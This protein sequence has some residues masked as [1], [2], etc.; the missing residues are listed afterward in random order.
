[1]SVNTFATLVSIENLEY[2]ILEF[3]LT[4]QMIIWKHQSRNSSTSFHSL[5]MI[6][7]T[8]VKVQCNFLFN[9]RKQKQCYSDQYILK[10]RLH[11]YVLSRFFSSKFTFKKDLDK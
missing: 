2:D 10:S 5:R 3:F 9:T 1:M 7:K 11:K 4:T 6:L 8:K